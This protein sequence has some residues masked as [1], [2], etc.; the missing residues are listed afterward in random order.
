MSHTMKLYTQ[1]LLLFV[2]TAIALPAT[3]QVDKVAIKTKGISCG[4]FASVS[5]I[6]LKLLPYVYK[7]A[8][9]MKNEAVLVSY[10]AG[11]SFQPKELRDILK[12]TEVGITQFQISARGRVQEQAGKRFFIAGKDKF[13]LVTGTN[14]TQV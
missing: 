9:S 13:L 2:F 3:A 11:A 7:V 6:Y 14:A 10:K 5:E 8:I 4:T 1:L 12:K